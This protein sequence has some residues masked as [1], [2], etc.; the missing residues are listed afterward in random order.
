MQQTQKRPVDHTTRKINSAPSKTEMPILAVDRQ[1][2]SSFQ[3]IWQF[4]LQAVP[5]SRGFIGSFVTAYIKYK[6]L[7]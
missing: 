2:F 4:F 7:L 1:F 3:I 6:Q 5:S